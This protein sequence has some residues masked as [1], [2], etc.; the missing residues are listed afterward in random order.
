M[1]AGLRAVGRREAKKDV[2]EV[3]V[4]DEAEGL[5][6]SVGG[7]VLR[8]SIGYD[9][10]HG[11]KC[12]GQKPEHAIHTLRSEELKL[13]FNIDFDRHRLAVKRRRLKPVLTHRLESGGVKAFPTGFLNM[14]SLR[15][16][17]LGDD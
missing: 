10:S 11:K 2:G 3:L 13:Y 15:E 14:S 17:S 9:C 4:G 16:S 8:G 1:E 5:H 12:E 7:D 6:G